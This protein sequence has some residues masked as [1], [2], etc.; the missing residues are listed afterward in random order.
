M[1]RSKTKILAVSKKWDTELEQAKQFRYLG[2][3]VS[4]DGKMKIEVE[5]RLKANIRVYYAMIKQVFNKEEL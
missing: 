5:K 4:E 2:R 1:N 3:T